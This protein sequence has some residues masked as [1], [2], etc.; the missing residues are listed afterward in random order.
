MGIREIEKDC[1]P[2][3]TCECAP[4]GALDPADLPTL[5][6]RFSLLKRFSGDRFDNS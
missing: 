2:A 1:G 3:G 5:A 6:F 4:S